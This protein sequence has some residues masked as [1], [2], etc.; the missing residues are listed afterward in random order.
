[1]K[2]LDN[3]AWM[4]L[5][6]KEAEEV[7]N[8]LGFGVK[9]P[10]T[11]SGSITITNLQPSFRNDVEQNAEYILISSGKFIYSLTEKEEFVD[12]LY[13]AK[14]PVTN[15]LYRSFIAALGEPSGFREKL[16]EIA[17]NKTW[18]AGFEE[19]LNGG[20]GDLATLFRSRFD[21]DRKF[22]GDDQP[23]VGVTCYAASA[24]CL[25]L[26]LLENKEKGNT[27]LLPTEI[28]W[29]WAAGG[30]QG[31]PV[32][33]VRQY[34]WLEEK[35]EPTSKLANFDE[36]VGSTTSVG[37][38]PEGATPEGLYDMAGNVWEWMGNWYDKDED[39]RSLRG[40]SWLNG[41]VNLRCSAR[42]SVYPF[43]NDD[44]V[45]GFRVVRPGHSS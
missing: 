41:S 43:W 38:Y 24:Y 44:L 15:K 16:I 31:V 30:R 42:S 14:Y 25:W 37:S 18:D 32:Q 33:K 13:V 39:A 6:K 22:G 27:Y 29:E 28:E 40:G 26:S 3:S 7:L 34:P 12:D 36:N 21:E 35:G 23:V 2:N 5:T 10:V 20:K 8:S 17:K 45:I 11:C 1:M 9:K 4:A 19:Y